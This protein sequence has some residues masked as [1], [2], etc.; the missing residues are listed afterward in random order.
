[1]THNVTRLGVY[2]KSLVR[3]VKTQNLNYC[4]SIDCWLDLT[5]WRCLRNPLYEIIAS[6]VCWL[7][8]SNTVPVE[9]RE[10]RCGI[11]VFAFFGIWELYNWYRG[12]PLYVPISKIASH[13]LV[14]P[15]CFSRW[16]VCLVIIVF[17]N[18]IA[19][20]AKIRVISKK[21]PVF[22]LFSADWY[23]LSCLKSSAHIRALSPF[24]YN[25]DSQDWTSLSVIFD[26]WRY[27]HVP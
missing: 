4:E 14:L 27:L 19:K 22:S 12:R 21:F 2:T 20:I 9:V 1:M 17:V 26:T 15:I 23:K 25:L 11:P 13:P 7:S 16:S 18:L 24:A 10:Y 6:C 8:N 5:Y 3:C